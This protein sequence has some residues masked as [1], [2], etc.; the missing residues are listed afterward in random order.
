[1]KP[2]AFIEPH[3]YQEQMSVYLEDLRSQPATPENRVMAAGDREWQ[4]E[5]IRLASGIPLD[6]A[7]AAEFAEL[8]ST[9][10]LAELGPP[11]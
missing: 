1:M 4:E 11:S 10:G 7:V 5:A 9:Y 3:L 8:A 2:E 6:A